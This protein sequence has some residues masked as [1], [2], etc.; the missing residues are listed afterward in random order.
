MLAVFKRYLKSFLFHADM[1]RLKQFV[2]LLLLLLF[3]FFLI[4]IIIIIMKRVRL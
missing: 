3:Y 4:I 1:I 2:L